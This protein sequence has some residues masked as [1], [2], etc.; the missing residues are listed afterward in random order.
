MPREERPGRTMVGEKTNQSCTS[1]GP[2]TSE[3]HEGLTGPGTGATAPEVHQP[4]PRAFPW[5][6]H[7]FKQKGISQAGEHEQPTA[8]LEVHGGED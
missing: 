3:R 4:V 8:M 6:L 1:G 5:R 7:Q 2:Q